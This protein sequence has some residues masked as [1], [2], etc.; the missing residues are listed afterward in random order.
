[1]Y[2]KGYRTKTIFPN[3]Y[4]KTFYDFWWTHTALWK[5]LM[6]RLKEDK[7]AFILITGDTSTGKS[8]LAGNLIFKKAMEEDNFIL[9]DGKK[10][11]IPEENYIIDPEEFSVKMITSS[12]RVLWGDEFLKSSDRQS[13]FDPINKAIITRKNTNRKLNNIYIVLQP[14][15]TQF[16]PKLASHLTLW[17]WVKKRGVAELYTRVSGRKGGKGLDIQGIIDRE[18]KYRKENPK[19]DFVPPTIHSEYVGRISW[20]KLTKNL[21]ILYNDLVKKKSATGSLTNEEKIKYGIEV[22]KEPKEFVIDAIEKIKN[23]KIKDKKTLW[24]ELEGT[25]LEDDKKLK[26]LNFYLKL[27]NWNGFNKLF[28]KSSSDVTQKRKVW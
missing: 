17:V 14:Y 4:S 19:S 26:L 5:A 18:E 6:Q 11:F 7:D 15:E 21:E 1:M 16:N 3:R 2:N 12:G 23:G 24:D 25:E 27:E 10:M 13:W 28:D 20:G 9:N 22:K 8:H